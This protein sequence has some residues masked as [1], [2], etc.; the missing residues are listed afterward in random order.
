MSQEEKIIYEERCRV[1]YSNGY[2]SAGE[3]H[4]HEHDHLYVRF[5][6]EGEE[7]SLTIGLKPDEVFNLIWLLVS[8]T[9]LVDF[10]AERWVNHP[11]DPD[12][13]G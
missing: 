6:R 4:G 10:P 5:K 13:G 3:V 12:D 11:G 1:G 8:A 2:M 9:G 7:E